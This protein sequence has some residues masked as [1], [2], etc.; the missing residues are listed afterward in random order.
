MSIQAGSDA[1]RVSEEYS[2][3]DGWE[4]QP[5]RLVVQ[6]GTGRQEETNDG[7]PI[8]DYDIRATRKSDYN[9]AGKEPAT[10]PKPLLWLSANFGATKRS[11]STCRCPYMPRQEF[12]DIVKLLD[13]EGN[14][15][16]PCV[17]L[18]IKA[19]SIVRTMSLPL[20]HWDCIG[21]AWSMSEEHVD[22][23]G[24]S[25]AKSF[26]FDDQKGCTK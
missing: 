23:L 7:G 24:R 1:R 19:Q 2:N 9:R 26:F 13:F 15:T 22:Y 12:L 21:S 4:G 14:A 8:Y 10:V 25:G 11:P 16:H 5:S 17:A 18:G 6:G 3:N 20:T